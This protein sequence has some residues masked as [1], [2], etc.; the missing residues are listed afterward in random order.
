MRRPM[1]HLSKMLGMRWVL[2]VFVFF[3]FVSQNSIFAQTEDDGVL[4][5]RA[6]PDRTLLATIHVDNTVRISDAASDQVINVISLPVYEWMEP[7]APFYVSDMAFSPNNQSLALGFEG[8]TDFGLI[9]I[10]DAVTDQV[11]AELAQDNNVHA[12]MWSPDGNQLATIGSVGIGSAPIRNLRIWNTVANTLSQT[13]ELVGAADAVAW[14]PLGD[15]LAGA[16]G[17]GRITIWDTAT[18]QEDF[19]LQE[20]D[21][22]SIITS[23]AW[24]PNGTLLASA[25]N[26][27]TIRIWDPVTGQQLHVFEM[28][29]PQ[30]E[31]QLVEWNTSGTEI[32]GSMGMQLQVWNIATEEQTAVINTE[33]RVRGISWQ[34]DGT[35]IYALASIHEFAPSTPIPN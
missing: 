1:V 13:I 18:W 16:N 32:L 3:L 30:R 28:G 2:F 9:W 35:I 12:L 7:G 10:V 5:M 31:K 27:S 34:A 33:Q 15:K 4:L 23:L 17:H 11:Q 22:T 19:T 26:D 25:A 29:E 20:H 24:S 14:S 6:S 21:E 8:D